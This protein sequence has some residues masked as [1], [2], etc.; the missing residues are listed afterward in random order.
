MASE[1]GKY[2]FQPLRFTKLNKVN[3]PS[4]LEVAFV[5]VESV[6]KIHKVT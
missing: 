1:F 6:L 4:N 3:L 5:I 2:Q